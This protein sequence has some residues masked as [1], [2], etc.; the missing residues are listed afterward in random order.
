MAKNAGMGN[1]TAQVLKLMRDVS[2]EQKELGS[3][4]S[5]L[6]V[7]VEGLKGTDAENT[8][9]KN[10]RMLNEPKDVWMSYHNLTPRE[11]LDARISGEHI[12]C[13]WVKFR[14]GTY[15]YSAVHVCDHSDGPYILL[16]SPNRDKS[17]FRFIE[18][19]ISLGVLGIPK[20]EITDRTRDICNVIR[21]LQRP[22][23]KVVA[24]YVNQVYRPAFKDVEISDLYLLHV[25]SEVGRRIYHYSGLPVEKMGAITH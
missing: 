13:T 8:R 23:P 25:P 15:S 24:Q 19:I 17:H 4:I 22:V 12:N 10:E 11:L 16:S 3:K 14:A 7:M 6:T 9:D 18:S 2:T 20:S 21:L 1:N 5:R